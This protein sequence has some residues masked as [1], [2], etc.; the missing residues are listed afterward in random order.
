MN[1]GGGGGRTTRVA[2]RHLGCVR[3]GEDLQAIEMDA[4]AKQL[5]CSFLGAADHLAQTDYQVRA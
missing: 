4:A 5:D 2:A 3:A 1:G